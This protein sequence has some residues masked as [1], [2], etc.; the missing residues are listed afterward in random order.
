MTLAD[1][2]AYKPAR[3]AGALPALPRLPGLHAARRRR[4][5]RRCWRRWASSST[6]TSPRAGP[7]DAQGWLQIA[8]AERLMYADRDTLRG[9]SGLRQVPARGPA[10][11]RLPRQ[12]RQADRRDRR[13][14]ADARPPGR[15]AVAYGP[16]ATAR[17]RR[18]LALRDRRRGGQRRLDDHHGREHLR[19][20][21]HGR[22]L[23]PQQPA[24]RLLVRAEGPRRR[25]GRQRGRSRQAPALVDG[26]RPSSWTTI[27]DF[28][29]AVGSPGGNAIPAFVLKAIVGLLDWKLPMQQALALPNLVARGSAFY[30]EPSRFAPGVVAGLA[31][32][33]VTLRAERRRGLRPARH[34]EGEG[35]LRGRRGRP[36]RGR[37]GG[38][39]V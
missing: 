17:A 25:A 37:G 32:K 24:D 31:A 38:V 34:H 21:P 29:A 12:P 8:E 20:R 18:H 26:A 14:A 1:L 36:A 35:R 33:G 9:R 4:A 15:R 30:S 27:G 3:G 2:A 19:R 11:P 16:D 6:P 5:A 23:L 13:P 22:R 10:R 7:T 39:L 28:V